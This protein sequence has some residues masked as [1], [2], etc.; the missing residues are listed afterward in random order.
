MIGQRIHQ[1]RLE[2]GMSL[3]ELADRANVAKSYLSAIERGLRDNPSLQVMEKLAGILDTS[4]QLL[5]HN[6]PTPSHDNESSVDILNNIPSV[7]PHDLDDEWMSL[8]Q[9]AIATGISA[10]QFREWLEFQRWRLN[11]PEAEQE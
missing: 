4:I 10:I 9:E 7:S 5:I 6:A 3:S 2:K 1:L 8:A 11:R